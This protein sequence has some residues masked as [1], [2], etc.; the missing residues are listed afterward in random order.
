LFITQESQKAALDGGSFDNSCSPEQVAELE[1]RAKEKI[2]AENARTSHTCDRGCDC[3]PLDDAEPQIT[4][5]RR[6]PLG[7]FELTAGEGC[8][9][10]VTEASVEI[11]LVV[12]KG[13][14]R[15]SQ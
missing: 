11:R 8:R 6:V 13:E 12:L 2:L 7:G 15:K 9:F 3:R 1:K 5:W 10:I 14:C 4:D